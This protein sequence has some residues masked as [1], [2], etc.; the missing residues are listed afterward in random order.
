MML[1]YEEQKYCWICGRGEWDKP[2]WYHAPWLLQRAHISAGSG[3]M[4]RLEDRRFAVLACARCHLVH[5]HSGAGRR[6]GGIDWPGIS[7]ANML[8]VKRERDSEWWDLEKIAGVWLGEVPEPEQPHK[9]YMDEYEQ[10][11]GICRKR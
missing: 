5:S 7:D 10:R 6:V 1:D 9:S 2:D 11:R 4:R 3:R 8:W